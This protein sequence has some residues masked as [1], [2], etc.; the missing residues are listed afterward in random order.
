MSFL[1]EIITN[2]LL[3]GFIDL[4]FL[5]SKLEKNIE[6]LMK[7]KWFSDLYQ[8]ARFEYIISNN[9]K[10]KRFL[11]KSENVEQLI[12]DEKTRNEFITLVKDE[13]LNFV[14]VNK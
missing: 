3:Y 11:V 5:K 4:P 8:D 14:R 9:K 13:H 10:I 7:E 6:Q 1:F 12:K 2:M